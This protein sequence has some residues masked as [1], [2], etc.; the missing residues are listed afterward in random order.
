MY[1][2]I[3]LGTEKSWKSVSALEYLISANYPVTKI[4]TNPNSRRNKKSFMG[5]VILLILNILEFFLMSI[6]NK[7][8]SIRYMPLLKR[9]FIREND[10]KGKS[11]KKIADNFVIPVFYSDENY[12]FD[13]DIFK[14]IDEKVI[15]LSCGWQWKVQDS[16]ITNKN[17]IPINI[18]D[19][20]L[21][22]YKSGNITYAPIINYEK[23]SGVSA[24]IMTNIF[25]DGLIIAQKQIKIENKYRYEILYERRKITPEV[26]DLAIL[27]INRE[28]KD[29]KENLAKK[30][31]NRCS[32]K[33]YIKYLFVNFIRKVF[34]LKPIKYPPLKR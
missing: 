14:D 33:V 12:K 6:R 21:P 19:S 13:N 9:I 8:F 4:L 11:L 23:Y 22:N 32:Y 3:F 1:E 27:K 10:W 15:L 7:R 26:I 20:F 16:F 24:H 31:Y 25:D 5:R 17:I 30:F 2:I 28:E 34:L 29:F 18:H